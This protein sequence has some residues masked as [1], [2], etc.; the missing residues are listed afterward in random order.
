[1][2]IPKRSQPLPSLGLGLSISPGPKRSSRSKVVRV[3]VG[4]WTDSFNHARLSWHRRRLGAS[5][6]AGLGAPTRWLEEGGSTG[7]RRPS[8]A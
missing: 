8:R 2:K 6:G 4:P 1:M 7:Q 5:A 3:R